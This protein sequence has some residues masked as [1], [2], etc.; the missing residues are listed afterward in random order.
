MI[1]KT[2]VFMPAREY[3]VRLPLSFC[4]YSTER[5]SELKD[6]FYSFFLINHTLIKDPVDKR[7]FDG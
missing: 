1:T 5:F 3:D 2:F 4:F 6:V 7:A